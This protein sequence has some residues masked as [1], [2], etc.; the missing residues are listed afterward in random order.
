[1]H[2]VFRCLA[3]FYCWTITCLVNIVKL[4]CL[5]AQTLARPFLSSAA[6]PSHRG[7]LL[8]AACGAMLLAACHP[9]E[10]VA[11]EPKPVVAVRVHPDART[12]SASLP[13]QVQ[14][15]YSTPLS[16]RIG[17]KVTERRV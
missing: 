15:R 6:R 7:R 12:A 4:S 13:A 10:T 5:N 9:R 17:G 16:F 11:P 8:I 1:M 3:H 14:A 2:R